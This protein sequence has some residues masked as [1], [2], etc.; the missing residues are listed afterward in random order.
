MAGA[1]GGEEERTIIYE[2]RKGLDHVGT[3]E[4]L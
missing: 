1:E 2:N 3:S 4:L